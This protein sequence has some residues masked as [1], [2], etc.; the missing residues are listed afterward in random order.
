MSTQTQHPVFCAANPRAHE[1]GRDKEALVQ[2]LC[3]K[4]LLLGQAR[5]QHAKEAVV[6][7][8]SP[9]QWILKE[10]CAVQAQRAI[11]ASRKH[12]RNMRARPWGWVPLRAGRGR[13]LQPRGAPGPPLARGGQAGS[14]QS[15]CLKSGWVGRR[16][17][18]RGHGRARGWGRRLQGEVAQDI[19]AQGQ[20]CPWGLAHYWSACAACVCV[21][22]GL[23][24][25]T[26]RAQGWHCASP[27]TKGEGPWRAWHQQI[28]QRCAV[29]GAELRLAEFLCRSGYL[30]AGIGQI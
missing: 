24:G 16:A 21:C 20:S 6:D 23:G 3:V 12:R 25:V 17:R 29:P 18:W 2:R 10:R 27:C 9:P 14:L 26:D 4:P 8:G 30:L 11:W 5:L 1:A 28:R 22:T 15:N 19:L 7:K 13:T